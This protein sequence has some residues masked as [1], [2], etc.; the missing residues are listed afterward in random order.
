VILTL[1]LGV[2]VCAFHCSRTLL[3]HNDIV[4]V[5]VVVVVVPHNCKARIRAYRDTD[6]AARSLASS[7][8]QQ[9]EAAPDR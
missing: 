2:G 6:G 9:V 7:Q 1:G 8:L 3:K 5:I 4:Y